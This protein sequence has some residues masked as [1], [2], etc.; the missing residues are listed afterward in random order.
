MGLQYPIGVPPFVNAVLESQLSTIISRVKPI[1]G[2]EES[3][4]FRH[5]AVIHAF[6]PDQETNELVYPGYGKPEHPQYLVVKAGYLPR[7][8]PGR[9]A[10]PV[11]ANAPARNTH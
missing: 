4:I 1:N 5:P 7:I 8:S 2:V 6:V 3:N 9:K 10:T 11:R